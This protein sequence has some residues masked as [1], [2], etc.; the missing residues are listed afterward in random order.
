[1][2]GA[3]P[4]VET[5]DLAASAEVLAGLDRAAPGALSADSSGARSADRR[6]EHATQSHRPRGLASWHGQTDHGGHQPGNLRLGA[7]PESA[8]H[9]LLHWTL[10]RRTLPRQHN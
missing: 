9:Q 2:A 6:A 10:S 7:L 8:H 1:S 3:F 5:A 4:L